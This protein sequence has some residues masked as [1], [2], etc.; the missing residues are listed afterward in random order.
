MNKI[1]ETIKS[2]YADE[3]YFKTI[4]RLKK[5]QQKLILVGLPVHGNYGDHILACAEHDF[6]KEHFSE[7]ALVELSMAFCNAHNGAIRR[8]IG[9]NDV[10]CISGGGWMGD[11]YPHDED[12]VRGFLRDFPNKVIIFP[13]T[14]FY[15]NEDSSYAKEGFK[16]LATRKDVLLFCRDK[17]SYDLCERRGV[18][19][20]KL[21]YYPDMSLFYLNRIE[22]LFD[23]TINKTDTVGVCFRSDNEKVISQAEIEEMEIA[24]ESNGYKVETFSTDINKYVRQK[25]RR[26]ELGELLSKIGSYRFVLTDRLHA[27]IFSSLVGTKCYFVDNKTK[28]ISG[29]FNWIKDIGYVQQI[30]GI[31]A[32]P[33]L[34]ETKTCSIPASLIT[35]N[36]RV[37]LEMSQLIRRFI[38]E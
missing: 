10:I 24:V 34:F 19:K 29:V 32:T 33:N 12:F 6:I 30:E 36:R 28:K 37:F 20:E 15:E 4:A 16:L 23:I 1:K 5:K 2:A 13:Q 35:E 11:L 22:E 9:I 3:N 38:N 27:M 25:N 31:D 8:N 21:F 14:V 7:Y 18:P 17:R 26:R